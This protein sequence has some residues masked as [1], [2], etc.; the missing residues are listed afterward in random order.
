M[1]SRNQNIHIETQKSVIMKRGGNP[2]KKSFL[3]ELRNIPEHPSNPLAG[4]RRVSKLS[5]RE[6]KAL[7]EQVPECRVRFPAIAGASRRITEPQNLSKHVS[8]LH[9]TTE[10]KKHSGDGFHKS[11][12][13][14]KSSIRKPEPPTSK[15][16][17]S[18]KGW[19]NRRLHLLISAERVKTACPLESVPVNPTSVNALET[20]EN[21]SS[22][23]R[24]DGVKNYSW[25][26]EKA[27]VEGEVFYQD[28]E[29]LTPIPQ[30]A[31]FS[32]QTITKT[33]LRPDLVHRQP[34]LTR[35]AAMQAEPKTVPGAEVHPK[36][37]PQISQE[38]VPLVCLSNGNI[39]KHSKSV[40]TAHR[41][42]TLPA[43]PIIPKGPE[44]DKLT[45]YIRAQ[46][47]NDGGRFGFGGR[48][49]ITLD[50]PRPPPFKPVTRN[51]SQTRRIMM[52]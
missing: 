47:R 32:P 43:V 46:Q 50:L 28:L 40:R 21:S 11:Y 13:Q 18:K 8:G 6:S 33:G 42:K 26:C 45:S 37:L 36:L 1:K 10:T 52:Q 44:P 38:K 27:G 9:G 5:D 22:E 2:T 49:I 3:P 15:P 29:G 25:L 31:L 24:T 14:Q 23:K 39:K 12:E 7:P 41:V 17:T 51:P 48:K 34:L 19:T 20:L 35:R 30:P 4:R 16:K